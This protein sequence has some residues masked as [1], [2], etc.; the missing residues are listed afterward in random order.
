MSGSSKTNTNTTP[1][2][3]ALDFDG[4]ILNGLKEYFLTAWRAYRQI[5]PPEGERLVVD[6]PPEG[7]AEGFYRLRPVIETG[8]EM[9]VLLRALVLGE[10]EDRI[11][12]DWPQVLGEVMEREGGD[13]LRIGTLVDCVRDEWIE[14]DLDGWLAIQGFY[15]GTIER[16]RAWLAGDVRVF[17]VSTKEGRF[18]HRLLK[19]AGVEFPRDRIFGKEVKRPKYETLRLLLE[20]ESVAADRLWFVED[21]L[22]ALELVGEQADLEGVGLFLAGWGY[23]LERDRALV[24]GGGRIQLLDLERFSRDLSGWGVEII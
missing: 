4:V 21:R 6:K 2:I 15:P 17:I 24:S 18:I 9:P 14:R 13:R 16:L 10:S 19:Q 3:L 7:L 20:K 1:E 5:W 22:K 11:V 8:W 12:E 23:N